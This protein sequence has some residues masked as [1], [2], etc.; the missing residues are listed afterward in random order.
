MQ[1]KLINSSAIHCMPTRANPTDAG[2]DLR[3]LFEVTIHPNSVALI[4][5]GIAVKIPVNHVGL[6]FQRSGLTKHNITLANAVGVIDSDY[7]GQVLVALRNL[8][9]E[10]EFSVKAGDR[11]AQLVILPIVIPKLV[12]V[13]T[14]KEDWNDTS[15][16]SGGFGSTGVK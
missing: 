2:L 14:T 7:R 16:G 13:N 9:E 15:R 4:D 8:N 11:I 1:Y 12:E 6:V 3:A 10:T 5:T